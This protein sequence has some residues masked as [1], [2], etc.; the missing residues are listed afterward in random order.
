[1][2]NYRHTSHGGARIGG[3]GTAGGESPE[4]PPRV[5]GKS[6]FEPGFRPGIDPLSRVLRVAEASSEPGSLAATGAE[7]VSW[8]EA[9]V[10]GRAGER[11]MKIT[12]EYCGA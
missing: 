12:I 8:G 1:L 4:N 6:A 9:G 7:P 3:S 2:D 5:K 10:R 11:A